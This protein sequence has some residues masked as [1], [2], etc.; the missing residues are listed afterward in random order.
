MP[1]SLFQQQIF[2]K[3]TSFVEHPIGDVFILK[4]YAGTGKTT[5]IKRLVEYL[6]ENHI[7]NMVMAPTGRA[8]KVLRDK[9]GKGITIH[10]GIYNYN[11]L[12]CIEVDSDDVSKKS[13]R[14]IF[15]VRESI[16][17]KG[18]EQCQ[19]VIVDE[20]SMISDKK[21]IGEFFTFGS[22]KLLSDLLEFANNEGTKKLIFVGDDAQ[23]PPVTDN[24][25]WALDESYFIE[26]GYKVETA[27]LTEVMRQSEGSGI[28]NVA[29]DIRGLLE[30]PVTN[31]NRFVI[32]KNGIDVEELAI[33]NVID[34]YLELYPI[35]EVG[36]GVIVNFSNVQ[37]Y[38]MNAA[39]R[40]R[41]Y[42][43]KKEIQP[44]DIL[45]INNNNYHTFS[46]TILNGDMAKVVSTGSVE[47]HSNIPVSI[48]GKRTHVDLAF[49]RIELLFPD[50]DKSIECMILESQ[51]NSKE[52]DLTAAQ[53]R[54]LYIDFCMRHPKLKDGS[55]EFK[56]ALKND[57]YFNAL[58]VKY[59]Y[60]I[61]CHKAQG[62][63]WDK[64][65]VNYYYQCGLSDSMLRWC[66][67]ATT[68]AKKKLYIINAPHITAC[69]KLKFSPIVK[70]GNVP[71]DFYNPNICVET[72]FH[73][74]S[75]IV[76]V[77]LKCASI[78][79]AIKDTEY[80]LVGVRSEEYREN[81]DFLY[82]ETQKITLQVYHDKAG[83]F[84]HFPIKNDG[85]AED[86]LCQII[87]KAILPIDVIKYKPSSEN[88]KELYQR[89]VSNCN[90][91]GIT[92]SNIIECK[93]KF[94]VMYYLITDA[95]FAYIQFYFKNNDAF[96]TAIPKSELGEQDEKLKRLISKLQ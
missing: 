28:L 46:R 33:T 85:S 82:N 27:T 90:E 89:V 3:L 43:E 92:I 20:S 11:D 18:N 77:R 22:G 78:I 94:Y 71:V 64:V 65:F 88:F 59:G 47:Y 84:K 58:K 2:N 40:E 67:T 39:V 29:S 19:V 54:A 56:M 81:Y 96:S 45:L 32:E 5:M 48:N 68:R 76:G 44:G 52:G 70:I 53:Q 73:S 10:K 57:L 12:K 91:L 55:E 69:S 6:D 86:H 80:K 14:Y 21:V 66:Y 51:L 61:T 7:P 93:E 38:Q 75:V 16:G 31:R 79:D 63:E 35:P 72:P 87:E 41:L 42:G 49:R 74:S 62:G 30:Q 8:A 83:V 95:T 34:K 9:M 36:N 15:P 37:C 50:D 17:G 25:S 60:A 4:G 13:F 24:H 1:S 26:R 23:L